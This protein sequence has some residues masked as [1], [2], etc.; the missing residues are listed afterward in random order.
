MVT[1]AVGLQSAHAAFPGAN[2]KITFR[3]D[4]DS[5]DPQQVYTMKADGTNERQITYLEADTGGLPRPA[6]S[7]NGKKIAFHSSFFFFV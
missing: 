4:R 7:P 6:F 1:A 5:G 2:G 3:S